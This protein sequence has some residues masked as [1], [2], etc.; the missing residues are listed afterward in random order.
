MP[1]IKIG[2][3]YFDRP[4]T[5]KLLW[6]LLWG[7]CALS[8]ILEFFVHRESHFP[9]DDFFGFYAVLGFV[10]C[11]VCILVAKGLSFILK[12]DVTYYDED[13]DA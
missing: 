6:R 10:A 1:E 12:K 13:D 9:Q 2:E 4:Q 8:L 5:K 11:M 7:V 3:G